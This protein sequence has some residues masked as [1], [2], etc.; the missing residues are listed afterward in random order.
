LLKKS[1]GSL[2]SS[3]ILRMAEKPGYEY[4]TITGP[5]CQR[6]QIRLECCK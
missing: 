1:V 4:L 6:Q 3:V 2:E 5:Q